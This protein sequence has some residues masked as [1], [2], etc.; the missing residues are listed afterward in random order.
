MNLV[1]RNF[2]LDDIFD[3]LP[4][5]KNNNMKCDIYEKDDK[6]YIEMDVTGFKKEDISIDCDNGYLTITATS[7]HKHEEKE[8][9]KYLRRERVYGSYKRQFYIGDTNED[10]IKAEFN[11]V[12]LRV[13]VPKKENVDTK[14]KI[15]ID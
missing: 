9:K 12:M 6:Y 4:E 14:K 5:V 15:E 13:I 8:G 2:F 3:D 10:S 7:S 11:N 1:P